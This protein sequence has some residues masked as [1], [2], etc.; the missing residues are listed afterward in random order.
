MSDTD[1][2]PTPEQENIGLGARIKRFFIKL[3]NNENLYYTF[4]QPRVIFGLFLVGF[5]LLLALIGPRFTEYTVRSSRLGTGIAWEDGPSMQHYFGLTTWQAGSRDVFTLTVYG[6]RDTIYTSFVGAIIASTVGV[7]LGLVA[8]Y[9]GGMTDE[10]L[11]GVTNVF[12][13]FPQ[14]AIL[15]ILAGF[16]EDAMGLIHMAVLVGLVI[17]PWTARAVRSQTLSLKNESHVD[18]S[19][20]SS[21]GTV[22]IMFEDIAANMFSYIIMVFIQQ[23][24]GVTMAV[25]GL[26]FL[27]LGPGGVVSLGRTMRRAIQ[28]G[29]LYLNYW[30][31]GILPGLALMLLLWGMYF[32]YN[33]LDKVFNPELREM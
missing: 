13:T 6:L 16:L 2:S 11:M 20:I 12:L 9:I 7:I 19:R 31:W 30:W 18:L 14:L 10:I 3:K 4:S 25:V 22:R 32:I 33:G 26:E 24:L 28:E 5:I 1:I 21:N 15:I 27:G 29:A 17:W 23:F 8:G